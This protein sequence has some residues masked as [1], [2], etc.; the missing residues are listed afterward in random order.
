MSK[1]HMTTKRAASEI[2]DKYISA[3]GKAPI[4]APIVIEPAPELID[5]ELELER[6]AGLP[7]I[8]YEA[9]RVAEANAWASEP[10]SSTKRLRRHVTSSASTPTTRTTTARAEPSRSPT[11][12][13]GVSRS[14][15]TR[16]LFGWRRRSKCL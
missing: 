4:E 3:D 11:F 16:L 10:L 5:R 9:T 1:P 13:R 2:A 12:F 15:A 6:L 7:R 8:V 14:M